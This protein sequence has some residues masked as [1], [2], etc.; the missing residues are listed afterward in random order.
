MPGLGST[1]GFDPRRLLES[2][3]AAW[4]DRWRLAYDLAPWG[5]ERFDRAI[6]EVVVWL[7]ACHG[8][9]KLLEAEEVMPFLRRPKPPAE[10]MA[11]DEIVAAFAAIAKAFGGEVAIAGRA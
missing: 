5:E 6:G 9:K 2:V 7:Q 11:E 1:C 3:P 4:L 8:A 10:P